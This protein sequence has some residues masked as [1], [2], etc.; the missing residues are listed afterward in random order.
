V[1]TGAVVPDASI[2]TQQQA[3]FSKATDR[4]R[5]PTA[6]LASPPPSAYQPKNSILEN[7]DATNAQAPRAKFSQS[8]LC[9]VENHFQM[10]KAKANPGPGQYERYSEFCT[11]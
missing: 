6:K 11:K 1:I 10:K 7:V 4:F 5:V 8:R 3:T 9:A 2:R